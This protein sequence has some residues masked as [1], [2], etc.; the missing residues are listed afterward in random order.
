MICPTCKENGMRS[1]VY[2]QGTRSTLIG[3]TQSYYDE[4]GNYVE[5]PDPNRHTTTYLCSNGHQ[6][7]VTEG[8]ATL[9]VPT[10]QSELP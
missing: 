9:P 6:W 1:R 8:P 10:K 2:S 3:Y 4:N 5:N 7:T